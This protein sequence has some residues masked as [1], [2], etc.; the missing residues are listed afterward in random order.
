MG[1]EKKEKAGGG[2]A[3][4]GD[5]KKDAVAQDIVLKVDLHCSGCASKVRRAIK[6]APG[7]CRASPCFL[8][9]PSVPCRAVRLVCLIFSF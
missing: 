7:T 4:G 2:K 9:Q 6:N 8:N 3:D 1:E 5:K